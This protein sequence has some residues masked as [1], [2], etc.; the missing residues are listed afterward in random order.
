MTEIEVFSTPSCPYCTK[1]K[2]WLEE[3][4]YEFQEYDVSENKEKAR[5]MM[6]RTS[7]KGVPQTFVGDKEIVGFQPDEIRKAIE[8]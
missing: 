3:E 5:E 7:R 8:G 6:E 1:L 2:N 4:G